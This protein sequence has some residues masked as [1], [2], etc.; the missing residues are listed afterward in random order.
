MPSWPAADMPRFPYFARFIRHTLSNLIQDGVNLPADQ[1]PEPE[2]EEEETP[3]A[4]APPRA[5]DAL[6]KGAMANKP[7]LRFDGNI[8]TRRVQR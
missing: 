5:A 2:D 3:R 8:G 7:S 1:A 4:M 6:P